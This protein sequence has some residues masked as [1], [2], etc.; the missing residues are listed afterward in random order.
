MKDA[1]PHTGPSTSFHIKVDV[2]RGTSTLS[3]GMCWKHNF[4]GNNTI[5]NTN[6]YIL[7]K[8]VLYIHIF[9]LIA[10]LKRKKD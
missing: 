6:I 9:V 10:E 7:F 2:K 1:S 5:F 8:K 3:Y 4:S